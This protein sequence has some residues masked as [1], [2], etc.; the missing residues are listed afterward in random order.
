M[1]NGITYFRFKSPY[2]GDTVK[3]CGLEGSEIDNNFYVLESRDVKAVSVDGDD[4]VLTLYDG[5][6]I[7]G[8]DALSGFARDLSFEFDTD[9]GVLYITQN[10]ETTEIGGFAASGCC[11]GVATDSTL[12]GDGTKDNPLGVAGNYQTGHY[13]PVI[14]IIDLT[15][16]EGKIPEGDELHVGDRYVVKQEISKS[17]LLYDYKGVK[18][19]ACQLRGSDWRIP[20]KEDWDNMLNSIEP[21]KT[22]ANHGEGKDSTWQGKYAGKFLK[23]TSE[24]PCGWKDC[25]NDDGCEGC[26]C[27]GDCG[28]NTNPCVTHDC[29][30]ETVT[31]ETIVEPSKTGNDC[32]GFGVEPTGYGLDCETMVYFGQKAYFWTA[33]M[34]PSG[35]DAFIKGFDACHSDVWQEVLSTKNFLSLRLVKDYNGNNL[36]SQENVIGQSFDTV[37]MPSGTIWTATNVAVPLCEC[38]TAMPN[39]PEGCSDTEIVYN[40]I[41]WNGSQWQYMRLNEGEIVTILDIENDYPDYKLVNGEFVPNNIQ[42]QADITELNRKID[43]EIDNRTNADVEINSRIDNVVS[44]ISSINESISNINSTVEGNTS[45]IESLKERVTKLENEV[46]NIKSIIGEYNIESGTVSER[47]NSIE[48]LLSNLIDFDNNDEG[49]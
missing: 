38:H 12:V 8:E 39:F 9:K 6:T 22:Y 40:I 23:S 29:G 46:D 7:T 34:R 45:D 14:D 11:D 48:D 3:N 49:W 25:G 35:N 36:Y 26:D 33:D 19:I 20:T 37:L 31:D 5:K 18:S 32:Y 2:E 44:D 28:D 47:L 30:H 27:G 16:E 1:N 41:E 15:T 24:E 17:G 10:G 13:K 42:T 43:E 21:D 4:I